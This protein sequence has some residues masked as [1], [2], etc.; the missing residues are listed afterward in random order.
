MAGGGLPQELPRRRRRGAEEGGRG[1]RGCR[2]GAGAGGASAHA[3][4]A[5]PVAAPL[6]W[7]RPPALLGRLPAGVACPAGSALAVPQLALAVRAA[8]GV[9][10]GH[11]H[12]ALLA[13]PAG[14]ADARARQVAVP[15]A[16]AAGLARAVVAVEAADAEAHPH[17]AGAAA[18]A[19]VRTVVGARLASVTENARALAIC[20]ASP[21]AVA[22]LGT[23]RGRRAVVVHAGESPPQVGRT[24]LDDARAAGPRARRRHGVAGRPREANVAR[25]GPCIAKS[26]T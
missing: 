5:L 24:G 6:C 1:R 16:A 12:L 7:A 26:V 21:V 22:V 10:A 17:G 23:R 11:L 8:R 15:V 14:L 25:A 13:H 3:E 9:W 20:V 18:A 2:G 4:T 19:V